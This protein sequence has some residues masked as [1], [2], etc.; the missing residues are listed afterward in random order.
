[1]LADVNVWVFVVVYVLTT[2]P[3]QAGDP[4]ARIVLCLF[5]NIPQGARH[6]LVADSS[7]HTYVNELFHN[8]HFQLAP[9]R[10][11]RKQRTTKQKEQYI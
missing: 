4:R 1:M 2:V 7:I 5:F 8:S 9:H 10:C 6:P 3:L 11:I